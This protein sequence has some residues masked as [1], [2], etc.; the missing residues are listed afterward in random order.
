MLMNASRCNFFS[1]YLLSALCL[2]LVKL[3]LFDYS[4]KT[5]VRHG[6]AVPSL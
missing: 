5:S 3:Q 1:Q 2:Q 4:T 6:Q